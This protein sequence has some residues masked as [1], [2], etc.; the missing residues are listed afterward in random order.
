MMIILVD[1]NI[2]QV[3]GPNMHGYNSSFTFTLDE[4][5][6]VRN[7]ET[8]MYEEEGWT[9]NVGSKSADYCN[10]KCAKSKECA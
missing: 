9:K 7:M 5:L 3:I 8:E 6:Y 10:K 2:V 4:L 1:P